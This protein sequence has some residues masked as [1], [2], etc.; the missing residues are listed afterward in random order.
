[1]PLVLKARSRQSWN[2]SSSDI[3]TQ[4]WILQFFV[5]GVQSSLPLELLGSARWNPVSPIGDSLDTM[6]AVETTP[7]PRVKKKEKERVSLSGWR[8]PSRRRESD[9]SSSSLLLALLDWLLLAAWLAIDSRLGAT[10]VIVKRNIFIYIV[11]HRPPRKPHNHSH[12]VR[13]P[14]NH[15]TTMGT[16][17]VVK[18]RDKDIFCLLAPLSTLDVLLLLLILVFCSTS[19]LGGTTSGWS[20]G[21]DCFGTSGGED[22]GS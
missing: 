14:P 15:I 4:V 8:S 11:L 3:Q 20:I 7:A 13:Q 18:A 9:L 1:M 21:G 10:R 2:I 5:N 17:Y 6:H 19:T 12:S 22:F 16:R